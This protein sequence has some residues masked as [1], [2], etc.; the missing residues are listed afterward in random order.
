MSEFDPISKP[1]SS[2]TEIAPMTLLALGMRPVSSATTE[3]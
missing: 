1:S 2:T 3:T